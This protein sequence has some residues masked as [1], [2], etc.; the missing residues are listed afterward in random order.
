MH[1]PLAETFM[2]DSRHSIQLPLIDVG[3]RLIVSIVMVLLLPLI[4]V[5]GVTIVIGRQHPEQP[6]VI[7]VTILVVVGFILLPLILV[8]VV[9]R[10]RVSINN[11]ELVM[12]TGV[13]KKR[14]ALANLRAHGMQTIDLT[15][16]SELRP[17]L[18]TWGASMPGFS[19]GWFRLRNGEKAVCV[20]TDQRHVTYLRSNAD[21]LT[22]LLSLNDP[23]PLKAALER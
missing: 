11:D 14:I 10:A 23:A 21:N 12:E 9:K 8:R 22:L 7:P 1:P 6:I 17:R 5:A 18:H 2:S 4:A 16:R 19:S 13:G 3:R 20:L 15:Q